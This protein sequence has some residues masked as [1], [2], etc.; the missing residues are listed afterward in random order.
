MDGKA[1]LIWVGTG[2]E[3]QSYLLTNAERVEFMG[4]GCI[5]GVEQSSNTKPNWLTGRVIYLPLASVLAVVEYESVAAYR[6]AIK[7]YREAQIE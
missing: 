4:T 7:Q 1:L 6:D 5:K 3:S 2:K